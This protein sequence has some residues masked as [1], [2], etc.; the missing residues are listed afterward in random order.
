MRVCLFIDKYVQY[1]WRIW[2]LRK[3]F[4]SV[5][6][7]KGARD[8]EVLEKISKIHATVPMTQEK[9]QIKNEE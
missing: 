3:K 1:K 7:T 5:N 8:E 6:E 2:H 9:V 4:H